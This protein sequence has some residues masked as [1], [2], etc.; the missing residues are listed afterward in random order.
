GWC[1]YHSPNVRPCGWGGPTGPPGT[2]PGP[3]PWGGPT[4]GPGATGGPG[5]VGGG[6]GSGAGVGVGVGVGGGGGSR[7]GAVAPR[8]SVAGVADPAFTSTGAAALLPW[9][10]A[11]TVC[12]PGLTKKGSSSGVL[13][14]V[15]P[16]TLTSAPWASE[17][18]TMKPQDFLAS[19]SPFSAAARW[20][21]LA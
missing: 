20:S 9:N 7:A 1:L 13:P 6:V 4:G 19:T 10:A 18:M 14:T 5:G 16:S 11:N 3:G 15:L 2:S 8:V 12:L 21:G 17:L